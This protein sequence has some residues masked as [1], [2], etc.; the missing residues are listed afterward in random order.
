[1]GLKE[2]RD[3]L[4]NIFVS[5]LT[6]FLI[7]IYLKQD[8]PFLLPGV[9]KKFIWTILF[10]GTLTALSYLPQ[11]EKWTFERN[12]DIRKKLATKFGKIK[13]VR[14]IDFKKLGK[15]IRSLDIRKKKK[16][17]ELGV[18]NNLKQSLT[19][20]I[21]PK[22]RSTKN[23]SRDD[24]IIEKNL[25]I[26]FQIVLITFLGF[27]LI[28]EFNAE[29]L[30]FIDVNYFLI[31]VVGFGALSILFPY[32]DKEETV[33]TEKDYIFCMVL[34]IIGAIII[35]YQTSGIGWISYIIS[36]VSG[37]FIILLSVFMLDE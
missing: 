5:I 16:F 30:K 12:K 33:V 6:V 37:I 34:G 23:L 17:R 36:A 31:T 24:H 26:A 35:F 14:N 29:F 7:L 1:M 21:K 10:F 8:N 15:R 9:E 28:R 3:I 22:K 4:R 27:L 19:N 32:E 20:P 11:D 13:A 2:D 18:S 25:N